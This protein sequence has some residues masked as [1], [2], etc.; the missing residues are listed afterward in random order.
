MCPEF[1]YSLAVTRRGKGRSVREGLQV[2]LS[3]GPGTWQQE[4]GL[5]GEHLATFD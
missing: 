3:V 4:A 2:L 5:I 1:R